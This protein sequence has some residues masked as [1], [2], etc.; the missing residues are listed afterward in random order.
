[1]TDPHYQEREGRQAARRTAVLFACLPGVAGTLGGMRTGDPL[2]LLVGMAAGSLIGWVLWLLIKPAD[3]PVSPPP[4][5]D[6]AH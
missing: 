4:P 3:R 1:M 5:P 6:R 2:A